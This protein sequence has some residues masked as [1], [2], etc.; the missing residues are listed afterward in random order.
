MRLRSLWVVRALLACLALSCLA[1]HAASTLSAPRALP[2]PVLYLKILEYYQAGG[3]NFVRYSFGVMN[4]TDYPNEM[5]AAAPNLP[6][7]GKNAKSA[8]TWVDIYD[9]QGKRLN[10]FCALSKPDDL[11]SIWFALEEGVVPPSYVYV[12]LNDRATNT[13]YK[14]NLADT[15]P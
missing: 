6:P 3:K 1:A 10:G 13:K 12:E 11:N 4:S 15:T 5:F 2:N 14:S 7:C 9:Q 8:R